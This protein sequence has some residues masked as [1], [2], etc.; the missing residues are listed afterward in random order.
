M[1]VSLGPDVVTATKRFAIVSAGGSG[2]Q[3]APAANTGVSSMSSVSRAVIVHPTASPTLVGVRRIV[4]AVICGVLT[5]LTPQSASAAL[6]VTNGDFQ[7][8]TGLTPQSGAPGWYVGVPAGWTGYTGS[9]SFNVIDYSSGNIGA[10]LQT[11]SFT[12]V[13]FTP[14]YQQIGSLSSTATITVNFNV[15]AFNANPFEVGAAIYDTSTGSSPSDGWA[16]LKSQAYTTGGL[17]SLQELNVPANTPLAIGFWQSS[18][19]PGVDNISVVPE[20]ASL[21]L[22]GLAAVGAMML[23]RRRR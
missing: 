9:P 13:P 20:P 19:S 1:R 2:T 21:A 10:N 6:V 18:G 14:L 16:V 5:L 22:L 8:L 17:Q 23:R 7:D 11:L 4:A 15:L 3:L 12:S